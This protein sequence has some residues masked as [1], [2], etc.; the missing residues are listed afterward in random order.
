MSQKK[1]SRYI[2]SN[3]GHDVGQPEDTSGSLKRKNITRVTKDP[4]GFT[5][6]RVCCSWLKFQI[7]QW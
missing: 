6:F 7:I 5:T 1:R 2:S 4:E 3:T